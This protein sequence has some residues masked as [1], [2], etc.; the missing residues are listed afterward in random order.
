MLSLWCTIVSSV[1][2][3]ACRE[4]ERLGFWDFVRDR[5]AHLLEQFSALRILKRVF[6]DPTNQIA[7]AD[8]HRG[9]MNESNCLTTEA[10]VVLETD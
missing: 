2:I 10:Q 3:A 1:C 5:L 9:P 6:A 8:S 4:T 7:A